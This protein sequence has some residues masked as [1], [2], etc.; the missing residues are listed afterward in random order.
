MK[1]DYSFEIFIVVVITTIIITVMCGLSKNNTNDSIYGEDRAVNDYTV[2]WSNDT[3]L[4]PDNNYSRPVKGMNSNNLINIDSID[5]INKLHPNKANLE[6]NEDFDVVMKAYSFNDIHYLMINKGM[7]I[8]QIA[9][10]IRTNLS[11]R[12]YNNNHNNSSYSNGY[13]EG[14][15]EGYEAAK[16]ELENK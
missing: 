6:V 15:E 1:R 10:T 9:N 8:H 16:K 13:D 12:T 11:N 2:D 4:E 7:T 5:S 14:Y 3:M